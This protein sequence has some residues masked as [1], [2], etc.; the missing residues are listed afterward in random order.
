VLRG[1]GKDVKTAAEKMMALRGVKH[2]KLTANS[3]G[4]EL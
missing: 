2:V 4:K 3:I 1:E